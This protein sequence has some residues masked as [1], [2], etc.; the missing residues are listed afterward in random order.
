MKSYREIAL[1]YH[2]KIDETMANRILASIDIG[3]A[4][5]TIDEL[6]LLS[7]YGIPVFEYNIRTATQLNDLLTKVGR[8]AYLD[9]LT[10]SI[11]QRWN[12]FAKR[13][14]GENDE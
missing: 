9:Y 13:L 10:H 12:M 8:G 4:N 3:N 1:L 5:Y 2:Y 7:Q 14:K 6:C 11:A